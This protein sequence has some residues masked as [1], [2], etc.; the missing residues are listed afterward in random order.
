[1]AGLG[2][3]SF[4]VAFLL[5]FCVSLGSA[6]ISLALSPSDLFLLAHPIQP[7][8]CPSPASEC[9]PPFVM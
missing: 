5:R 7:P 6:I 3:G 2:V 1:M 8:P 4:L 9:P